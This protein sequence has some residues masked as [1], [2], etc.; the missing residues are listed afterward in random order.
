M[1]ERLLPGSNTVSADR[2]VEVLKAPKRVLTKERVLSHRQSEAVTMQKSSIA[3]KGETPESAPSA[4]VTSGIREMSLMTP[5]PVVP[6][7]SSIYSPEGVSSAGSRGQMSP[8]NLPQ[9]PDQHRRDSQTTTHL[10]WTGANGFHSYSVEGARG[11]RN[12]QDDSTTDLRLPGFRHAVTHLPDLKEESHEDSS[13]NTSTSNFR[14]FGGSQPAAFRISTDRVPA[15]RR[16]P[17]VRSS[18][19]SVLQQMHLPSMNFSS[20]GSFDEAMDHRISRSLDLAPAAR[21]ELVQAV[22][23]RSASAGEDREKY[24]SVFAGL[25]TPAKTS[26]TRQNV[27]NDIWSR[28][29]PDLLVKE[30]DSLTIPSVNG[31]TIRL[32]EILPQLKEALGLAP[33]DEFP[34]EE[35]IMEKAMEKLNEVGLPAQ[36]RSSAR[37][38]PVRGSPNMLVV[39]DEVFKEITGKEKHNTPSVRGFNRDKADLGADKAGQGGRP[40]VKL[41]RWWGAVST[42]KGVHVTTQR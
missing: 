36:K 14:P 24:K 11:A 30:V 1:R 41:P 40:R 21:E 4:T 6:E 20:F 35:G 31:L 17:S 9:T 2:S 42:L 19:N 29:S 18:R 27:G 8:G 25:D 5:S 3:P 34:D 15:T 38:R 16:H 12:S 26:A 7:A 39:D 28:K 37:L 10:S 33:A 13:L 23:P 22:M 32:S